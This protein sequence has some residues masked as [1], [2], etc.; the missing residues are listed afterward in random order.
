MFRSP[1]P[2]ISCSDILSQVPKNCLLDWVLKLDSRLMEWFCAGYS[3]ES[4]KIA[5]RCS[6]AEPKMETHQH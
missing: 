1:S 3:L 6:P 5:N 2:S 4:C